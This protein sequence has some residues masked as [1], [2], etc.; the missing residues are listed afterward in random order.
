MKNELDSQD[1][2]L[3]AEL[4]RDGQLSPGKIGAATGVTAPT[5]RSRV[6]NLMRAGALKVAGMVNPMRV[7][8]LTVALVGISLMSHE[9]LG[10][11]LDQIGALPRVNWAAVVTGRYDIIVE[12][13]CQEGMDDLYQFLDQ[14]LSKVGGINASESFVVMK[15]RRKWLLLPDAVIETFTK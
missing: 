7:K 2:R 1:K 11:K 6:K 5:V 15:S 14:D 13:I 8:G 3:V 12:I 9:Q 4:T 10:E